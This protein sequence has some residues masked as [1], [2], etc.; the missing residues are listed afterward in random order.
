[1]IRDLVSLGTRLAGR[2]D[3]RLGRGLAFAV[4]EALAAAAPF[5]LV[6]AF[7]REALERRLTLERVWLLSGL[8]LATVFVRM[9]FARPAMANIFIATHALMGRTRLRIAD[10][11]RRLPMGF[12]GSRRSGELA[13]ILTTDIALVED[14]WSHLLGIFAAGFIQ[15][16]IVGAALCFLDWRLG[17]AVIV[18]LPLAVGAL[19]ATTPV[20]LRH[21]SSVFEATADANARIVEYVQGI[22]VLRAFGRHGDGYRRLTG[23]L[24]R[25]R[26]ALIRAE[27]APAPLLSIYGFVVEMGFVSVALVGS[28]LMLGGALDAATL[29]V[30]LVVSAGVTRQLSELGVALLTLRA[31]QKAL[32]R[33]DALL[34][35]KPLAEP[36]GAPP[37]IGSFDVSI[38][39]VSFTYEDGAEAALSNVSFT[40]PARRLTAIVGRSGSGKS[41]LVHL[42]ARLWDVPRGSGA[43]R[44][45][46][47][48]VRDIPFEE[49]HR[50]LAMVFQDVVLFS[51]SVLDNIRIGRPDASRDEVVRAARAAQAHAFIEAL[52]NG[53]D[54]RL[55]EGGGT[56]SGGERQRISI[57]RA[58]LKDAPVVLLDEA[59]A[60]VDASAEAALQRAIDELVKD[61]TVVVIAHRL[62]TIRRADQIVVLDG[63]RVVETGDHHALILKDGTYAAL[64]RE[65]ERAKGWRLGGGVSRAERA[66]D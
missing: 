59:T 34:A 15:P 60:S 53:Y 4:F 46:G 19:A 2:S 41:T 65:Q 55:G 45:G 58:I 20:F 13:G 21:M 22:A 14:I 56:L 42:I 32:Q 48:D 31:A 36:G 30:F 37:S 10:H 7:V 50:H 38:E 35:E 18:T 49:L 3:P 57:A 28:Y 25:L 47:V 33:I 64:W 1:M 52:P 17:L 29:L 54:T 23:A 24:E 62:R 40:L 27:V 63:G 9:A 12:F 43:I 8:A 66:H 6:L 26:D 11:L 16:F 51:G 44:I 39:D 5:V 61:K